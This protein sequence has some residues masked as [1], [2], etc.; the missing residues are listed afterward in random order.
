MSDPYLTFNALNAS[1]GVL[2]LALGAFALFRPSKTGIGLPLFLMAWGTQITFT[3]VAGN[4]S[5]GPTAALLYGLGEML[6]PLQALLLLYYASER[7]REEPTHGLIYS[8]CRIASIVIAG[9]ALAGAFALLVPS[10]IS[11]AP[12]T[13]TGYEEQLGILGFWLFKFPQVLGITL[14]L[15]LLSWQAIS[16]RTRATDKIILAGLCFA[17]AYFVG[18]GIQDEWSNAQRWWVLLVFAASLITTAILIPSHWF[19][20]RAGRGLALAGSATL[21]VGL[22][23]TFVPQTENMI[24]ALLAPGTFRLMAGAALAVALWPRRTEQVLL[25][26]SARV[27]LV[28]VGAAFLASLVGF[29]IRALAVLRPSHIDASTIT[30]SLAL[31]LTSLF[32]VGLLSVLQVVHGIRAFLQGQPV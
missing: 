25:D 3:N 2:F 32:L 18:F 23:G 8:L 17:W 19:F 24:G 1:S 22:L 30:Y 11:T 5:D 31:M 10:L 29:T 15:A 9:G 7:A 4:T 26:R 20:S 14:A 27:R 12:P 6:L 16:R 28:P 13:A 21:V